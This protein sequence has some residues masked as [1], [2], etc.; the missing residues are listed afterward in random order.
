M[1]CPYCKA[2]GVQP[3][4][5]KKW[6][7]P[8]HAHGYCPSCGKHPRAKVSWSGD[9]V[10]MYISYSREGRTPSLEPRKPRTFRAADGELENPRGLLLT[11]NGK[12]FILHPYT[13]TV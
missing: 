5:V 7:T 2:D 12:R 3:P 1:K 6:E 8:V 10:K 9:S 4:K 13:E 11:I